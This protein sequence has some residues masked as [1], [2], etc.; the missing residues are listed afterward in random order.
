[1][2]DRF[3]RVK[4]CLVYENSRIQLYDDDVRRPDGAM[5]K[6]IRL[7][8]HGNPRGVV[9]VPRLPDGRLLLLRIRRYAVQDESL[10]F[11]RGGGR[12]GELLEAAAERELKTETG[13]TSLKWSLMGYHRPDTAIVMTEVGVLLA[14]LDSGAEHNLKPNPREAIS[15]GIFGQVSEV[16]DWVRKGDIRDGFT[17]GALALL[18]A[19]DLL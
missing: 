8:Y 15:A 7:S 5:G 6:Y 19:N 12:P 2:E 17:L 13:L 9:I 14:D 16:W 1:M 11:P 3:Q 10:E 18:R 4:E